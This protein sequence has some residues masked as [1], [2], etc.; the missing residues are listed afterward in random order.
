[1]YLHPGSSPLF[2]LGSRNAYVVVVVVVVVINILP[3]ATYGD[4]RKLI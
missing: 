4:V 3:T 2:L 1:M